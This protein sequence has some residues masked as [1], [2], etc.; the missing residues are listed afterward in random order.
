MDEETTVKVAWPEA[1][2]TPFMTVIVSESGREEVTVTVLPESGV[3][4]LSL[5]VTTR[6]EE[7]EPSAW[8]EVGEATNVEVA[9]LAPAEV[10]VT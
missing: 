6:I 3:P 10:K 4:M 1:F 8:T 2:V 5:S 9:A 7:S